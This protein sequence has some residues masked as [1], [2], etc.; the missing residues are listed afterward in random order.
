MNHANMKDMTVEGMNAGVPTNYAPAFTNYVENI[1]VGYKFYETAAAE[2]IIDYE[3]TVQYPFGY[4]L[5]YTS[6]EHKM[7]ELKMDGTMEKLE[8]KYL[9]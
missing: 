9:K 6:F 8:N 5:S 1:Y 2:G 4:G 3:K 7:S